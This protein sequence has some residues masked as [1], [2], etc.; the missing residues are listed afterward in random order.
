[1]TIYSLDILLFLFGTSLLFL[2]LNLQGGSNAAFSTKPSLT[3]RT[4]TQILIIGHL[5]LSAWDWLLL[6]ARAGVLSTCVCLRLSP[7]P[8]AW[9][10]L[11]RALCSAYSNLLITKLL[12]MLLWDLL[13][14]A[15]PQAPSLPFCA[16][17][18]NM[19]STGS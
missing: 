14:T 5:S 8:G 9:L 7:V 2:V 18:P 19:I 12:Q 11:E 6:E 16:Q 3:S 10:G 4:L 17:E 15:Q 13:G 1:M